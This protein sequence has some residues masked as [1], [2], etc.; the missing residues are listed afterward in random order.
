V[1]AVLLVLL[2]GTVA[3]AEPRA[4]AAPPDQAGEWG[5]VMSW[6]VI[7]T[8]MVLMRNN[9]V[10]V[11][12]NG[13]EAEVWDAASNQLTPVPAPPGISN[14]H[15][16]GQVVLPDGRVLVIGGTL[17]RNHQG[18]RTAAAFDPATNAWTLL[19]PMNH[20]R[21]Y[22]TGTVLA[23][24]R[25]LVANGE[26][27]A[28]IDVPFFEVYDP[29]ANTWTDL[30][31]ATRHQD[32]YAFNALLPG[33]QVMEA[34]PRPISQLLDLGRQA[35]TLGPTSSWRTLPFTESD[36][37]YAPGKII[38]AGGTTIPDL[39]KTQSATN[40]VQ[41]ID[42]TSPT[43]GWQEASPMAF[44]RRRL[45]LVLLADGQVMAVG[46]TAQADDPAQAVLAGEIWNP[47][48]GQ[49]TT[50]ASMAVPRMYHAAALL[51]PDG[52]VLTAGGEP[53]T[54]GNVTPKT[55]QI[56]S[57]PY[58]FRG[59]RPAIAAA[60]DAAR[61]GSAFFLT[62]PDAASITSV[63]AIRPSAVT[64]AINMDQRYVPLS[65]ARAPGGLT[66]TAPASGDVAPP[67]WY[68]LVIKNGNGVPSVASWIRF[69]PDVT[70]TFSPRP[71]AATRPATSA[72]FLSFRLTARLR[73]RTVRRVGLRIR[74][75]VR[76]SRVRIVRVRLFRVLSRTRRR[77][78][79]RAD[80]FPRRPGLLVVRLRSHAV[81]A[82]P[83]G[84]YE[85][86]IAAGTTRRALLAPVVRRFTLTR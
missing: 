55:A 26:D 80:R 6:S 37:I 78:V 18:I 45:N 57:P 51:L 33:G 86:Q 11:W 82:L 40:R 12:H 71:P 17:T 43:P 20:P 5:P 65:F 32:V 44:P 73:I 41:T 81:R 8:H 53:A 60:P 64:H 35:W 70:P 58:L 38:R 50:V 14:F 66:V 31:G 3:L 39:V 72:Q 9:R 28:G 36:A 76:R 84:R 77:L 59:P 15:C 21:W 22:P 48:T 13:D 25:V 4:A 47:G 29:A 42:M 27:Q 63:A 83:P 16:A 68:M 23:D 30:P 69:G 1:L 62:T 24:G 19:S 61:Y 49:W 75:H 2:A 56:Y 10:L 74:V 54:A 79:V 34:S 7:G 67:G 85:V 46:G 52:R